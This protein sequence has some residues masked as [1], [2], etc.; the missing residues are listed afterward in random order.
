MKYWTCEIR[1]KTQKITIYNLLPIFIIYL[2]AFSCSA[3]YFQNEIKKI[4]LMDARRENHP[5][6]LLLLEACH[7]KIKLVS[8]INR[9]SSP[10]RWVYLLLE[11]EMAWKREPSNPDPPCYVKILCDISAGQKLPLHQLFWRKSVVLTQVSCSDLSVIFPVALDLTLFNVENIPLVWNDSNLT[12]LEVENSLVVSDLML[13]L[14]IKRA[15]V[16]TVNTQ[17]PTG[18]ALLKH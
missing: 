4:F 16:A 6:S 17:K 11:N 18:V 13:I 1:L 8:Q 15:P 12:Q 7:C 5:F 2:F 14:N 9:F 3:R 10:C